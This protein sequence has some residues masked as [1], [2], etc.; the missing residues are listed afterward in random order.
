MPLQL[1]LANLTS[2]VIFAC[3]IQDA[4]QN[5]QSEVHHTCMYETLFIAKSLVHFR[6]SRGFYH[7]RF[8]Q[9]TFAP[10]HVCIWQSQPFVKI[11]FFGGGEKKCSKCELW[12]STT[13]PDMHLITSGFNFQH[14]IEWMAKQLTCIE[15]MTFSRAK[16]IMAIHS[17]AVKG[18]QVNLVDLLVDY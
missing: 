16:N 17:F 5:V 7:Q 1:C 12:Y 6:L 9:F 10:I 15:T 11:F 14:W 4:I 8:T 13:V 2:T 18:I 3:V